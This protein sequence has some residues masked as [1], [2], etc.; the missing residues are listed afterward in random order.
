MGDSLL[1]THIQEDSIELKE[2]FHI[3]QV[4]LTTRAL[5]PTGEGTKQQ[6][7]EGYGRL[8][9][10]FEANQ[11][12]TDLQVDFLSQGNGYTLSRQMQPT[13]QSAADLRCYA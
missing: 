1:T 4:R 6:L 2:R 8:P 10:S 12:Q 7:V 13:P 3:M 9:L 11:G 5:T